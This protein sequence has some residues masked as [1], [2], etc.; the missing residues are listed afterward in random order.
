M[1]QLPFPFYV[2]D[3]VGH[4]R[5]LGFDNVCPPLHQLELQVAG[6]MIESTQLNLGTVRESFELLM[7]FYSQ[8]RDFVS[9]DETFATPVDHD[10]VVNVFG[11]K[12]RPV[13]FGLVVKQY[14]GRH[15]SRATQMTPE[16]K[17]ILDQ[18]FLSVRRRAVPA[19]HFPIKVEFVQAPDVPA[20]D[21]H[22]QAVDSDSP[23]DSPQDAPEEHHAQQHHVEQHIVEES[24]NSSPNLPDGWFPEKLLQDRVGS[25]R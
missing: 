14:I 25:L 12:F 6:T 11:F 16:E 2:I 19:I 4:L 10:D 9:D 13:P 3:V 22:L 18:A 17:H 15:F 21:S 8:N 23:E 5:V 7:G 1:S 24:H 20:V